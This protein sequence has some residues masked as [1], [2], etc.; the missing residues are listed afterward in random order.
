MIEIVPYGSAQDIEPLIEQLEARLGSPLPGPYRSFLRRTNGGDPASSNHYLEDPSPGL[1]VRYFLG[2][3]LD[4]YADITW[5]LD[6]RDGRFPPG[7]LPIAEAE[8]GDKVLLSVAGDALGAVLYW[9]HEREGLPGE[10][11][12]LADDFDEFLERLV[13]DDDAYWTAMITTLQQG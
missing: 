6:V 12:L 7:T 13:P 4:Y 3:G 5:H 1:E 10:V 11:T 2:F 9:D 8:Q